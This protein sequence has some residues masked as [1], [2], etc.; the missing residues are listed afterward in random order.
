MYHIV[1]FVVKHKATGQVSRVYDI[2]HPQTL[3]PYFLVYIDGSFKELP[4]S[5]FEPCEEKK[6]QQLNESI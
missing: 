5:D 1:D 3:K 6:K 2:P 4:A